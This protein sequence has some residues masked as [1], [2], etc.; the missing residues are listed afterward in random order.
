MT[1]PARRQ[2]IPVLLLAALLAA[3]SESSAQDRKNP[4]VVQIATISANYRE[5]FE[6]IGERYTEMN[7]GVKVETI[8]IPSDYETW[9]RT[10]IEGGGDQVPDIMNAN[11][12]V[13]WEQKGAWVW[14]DD[15][16]HQV[17]PYTGEPWIDCLDVPTVERY[18]INGKVYLMHPDLIEI[19]VFYN[20]KVF[21]ELGIEEPETWREWMDSC[22]RIKDAGYIPVAMPGDAA[23]FWVGTMGWM[24]R[25]IGD[26]YLRDLVECVAARP[27]DWNYDPAR[28]E[29]F[30][31]NPDD[32]YNDLYV[33]LNQERLINCIL[34]DRIDFKGPRF[35]A[36]HERIKELAQYFQK[37]YMGTPEGST[38]QLFYQ[39]RAAM[40]VFTTANIVA[41]TR[42]LKKLDPEDRFDYGIF[43]FPPITDDPLCLG[44]FRGVGGGGTALGIYNKHEPEHTANC[45]DFLMYLMSPEAGQMLMDITLA[46]DQPINGPSTI[47]G[48]TIPG[49]IGEKFDVVTGRGYERLNFRGLAD[50]QESVREWVTLAHEYFAGRIG[51]EE[52][53]DGYYDS[54]VRA[55]PRLQYAYG[56]DLD[57]TTEDVPMTGGTLKDNPVWLWNPFANG[58]FAVGILAVLLAGWGVVQ[59]LR[60]KGTTRY[61]TVTAYGL[62]APTFI[63]LCFFSYYPVLS[64]LYHAFT[65]W[66][67]GL[68]P[69]WVGL[70]NIKTLIQDDY[71]T[72]GIVN[73]FV[74]TI[75]TLVKATVVPFLAAEMILAL[76]SPKL[77]YIVRTSFLLPMVVP[78]MVSL[79]IWQFIYD[80]NIGMLNRLLD[81][82]GL[83]ALTQSWLGEPHLALPSIIFMGFPWV[84]A[85]GLLIYMAGLMNIPASVH[86]AYRLESSSILR[87]IFAI[88]IPMVRGQTR[89]LVV[90]TFIMSLQDFQSVLI[91]TDGGPGLSTMLPALRMYHA[92]FR[93]S[94]FGYGAAIGFALF[95]VILLVTI[96]NF[97]LFK[98]TEEME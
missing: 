15:Y 32:L 95:C 80:P 73:M 7:P 33:V 14:L 68:A 78:A 24:F 84:G 31:Y 4:D 89:L 10:R 48:V 8:I 13:G 85:F 17:N 69:I 72:A 75:A 92:A 88:D 34:G 57:P 50:E 63:L 26:A 44:P 46:A 54:V 42:D 70:R 36:I 9:V 19:G 87:R 52:Y 67:P 74:L 83:G 23:S 71:L 58:I 60:S 86:E 11:Y 56:Y 98:P 21:R 18:R 77:K 90:L 6:A 59:T 20:K 25:L 30:T 5:A 16:L 66:E 49:E 29:N 37:G 55:V 47:K 53:L 81:T 38:I 39:Q 40:S 1:A 97:K 41:I 35:R 96:A 79:L 28:N 2:L 62:L 3:P 45:V 91:L 93:F 12:L 22:Q 76:R 94:H 61:L 43:W 65:E 51:I 64:G 27:G 82:I